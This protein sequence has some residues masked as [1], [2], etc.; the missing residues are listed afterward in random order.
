VRSAL[1]LDAGGLDDLLPSLQLLAK[2]GIGFRRLPTG[3]DP[4][5]SHVFCRSGAFTAATGSAM[6]MECSCA[7][8]SHPLACVECGGI[9]GPAGGDSGV[10]GHQGP[11][12]S[13]S[14]W[15]RGRPFNVVGL[16][17]K[18]ASEGRERMRWRMACWL[19]VQG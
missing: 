4:E 13:M 18:A 15:R 1:K 16:A 17:D 8:Q 11:A 6:F 2:E 19:G 5:H 7:T 9:H 12:P 3:L 14:R 10:R